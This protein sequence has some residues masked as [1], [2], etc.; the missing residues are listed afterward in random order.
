M[1]KKL[2]K[3]NRIIYWTSTILFAFIVLN[4]F[5]EKEIR[6]ENDLQF[7]T[8]K[9]DRIQKRHTKYSNSISIFDVQNNDYHIISKILKC[10]NGDLTKKLKKKDLVTIGYLDG[11]SITNFYLPYYETYIIRYKNKDLINFKC[12][13]NESHFGKR[14]MLA[15]LFV[16]NIAI[17][18]LLYITQQK[19]EEKS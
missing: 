4:L 15:I 17:L 3:R 7:K 2:N 1:I 18:Y 6:T 16:A 8:I 19:S 9:I 10:T 13:V 12:V 11:Y 5:L 14:K